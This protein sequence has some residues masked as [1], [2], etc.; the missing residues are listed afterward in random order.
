MALAATTP[1]WADG[2]S[3]STQDG[4]GRLSFSFTGTTNP[5]LNA[6]AT[7]GVLTIS[8]SDKTNIAPAS[9]VA[10]LPRI[11]SSGRADPDGKT[12]RFV[13]VAPVK[14]HVSQIPGHAVVDVA[15]PDFNGKM[16]DLVVP[17]KPVPKPVDVASLPEIKMR[18]GS[19]EK[20]TRLV[21]DWPKDVSYHVFPG[22]GKMT[23]KFDTPIRMDV[24]AVARFAPAWVRNVAWRVEGDS[25]IVEMQTDSDSGYHDFKDGR[26]VVLDILAPKTDGTAYAP[27]GIAKPTVTKME[28]AP[29][30]KAAA[31]TPP[32]AKPIVGASAAQAQAVVQTAQQL[33]D[34]N[35]PKEQPAP[36]AKPEPKPETKVAAAEPA[37]PPVPA[38]AA[39]A[40]P[41]ADGK[42]TRDGAVINFKGAGALPSAVF[43]RGL[44]AWV[45][46]E[47]APSFDS[48]NLKSALGD[49]A[50]GLEAVSS[51]GLGILRIT[52][53]Q[54]AEI[55]A[56]GD[57]NNL[58]V[59]IAGT[60]APAPVVIGFARNQND[61]RR[62]SLSTLLPAA[63]HAFRLL[64]PAGGDM[65]TIVPAQAG[66]GVPATR[67]FADFAALPTASGLVITPYADD[68]D[69]SVNATRV[70]I[71][72]PSGLVLTPPQMPVGQTPS[73]LAR[74][75]D[76]PSYLDF[77]HWRQASAGSFLATQRELIQSAVHAYPQNAAR[78][79][80]T[81]T[82]FYL[83]NG[84]GAEALGLIKLI[85][86]KDPSLAGDVQLTTMKAAAEY[87][88]GRYREAH[89]DLGGPGFDSDRHAAFWRGLIESAMEN[90]KDAHAHLEQAGP[91]MN[92]YAADWQ[93]RA[94]LAEADA[95]LGMGRLDLADAALTRMP[96]NIE[97]PLALATEL[98]Q[99]RLLSAENRFDNAL[100][101][102]ETVE[103]SGN[104][105]LAAE[106]IFYHT[107]AGLAAGAISPAQATEQFERLR[108]R[109]RGDGLELKTLR[110]LASLYFDR[111][112][113]RDGLRTL[114]IVTQNFKE[115]DATR[116][117]QD[118]MRAAF[119]NLFLKGGADKMKPVDA[120][121]LFYDNLDLTPV[122]PDGDEMIRR[123][124]DRLVAV[125]LLAPAASLLAYQVDKRLEGVAKAQ[126]ATRLAAV[127]LMDHKPDKAVATIRDSQISG[128]P[129]PET[130]E[131]MVLEARA[132]AALKQWDNA[133]DLI[134]VDQA[135]DTKRLRADI[136]WEAGNWA[137]AGQKIEELLEPRASDPSPLTDAERAQVLRA[138]VAYSLANDET[139]L[140]RLREHF[141]SR[142]KST[143][144]ANLFAVL[145]ADID[146]HGLAFRDA[147]ARIASVDTLES[148]MKDFSKRRSDAK[149]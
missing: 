98:T 72:R 30:T 143:S 141:V 95:G 6:S 3:G 8:F 32:P 97:A 70:T 87:M 42:R 17:P 2:V 75:G 111:G 13:L 41:V 25:T 61:P 149:S 51:N 129:D 105:R 73:A 65:L 117:A 122:G 90:W 127:Y 21:F 14:L 113:W 79:Q 107:N 106:A 84:F 94:Y 116:V 88:M 119:V 114:R 115:Q 12:L 139:S 23:V 112:Q 52:L 132:F 96:K 91:V 68:L 71:S 133:L 33:A 35:K 18:A 118:D 57:G 108:F 20:F 48:R 128:L 11:L 120:L 64:D 134:A 78:A 142:M 58:V 45:V 50:A 63:D 109:W 27:P 125:D 135:D 81:L 1:A 140:T 145:S 80:L 19:Y 62:S 10:A 37:A 124:S 77:D 86:T 4:Y 7:G 34:K 16:P 138:A 144:D 26:H 93:A 54:P 102:F 43:V 67:N 22:A 131:R 146:Q 69:V 60:V 148:F 126:V 44:T 39:P 100:A 28:A 74:F 76:G 24:S 38:Q 36:P 46:L 40:V 66:R 136:Y 92:R 59:E 56:R 47:N 83:A 137:T 99:A 121:A 110:K 5:R 104:E 53:K 29:A 31:V 9:V 103:K 15:P 82:R 55:S 85:Q 123:M 101:H 130:H 89:N 49:F 147:A